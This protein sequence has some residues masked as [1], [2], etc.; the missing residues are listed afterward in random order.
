MT[1][2][3]YVRMVALRPTSVTWHTKSIQRWQHCDRPRWHY[4]RR[5]FKDGSIAT[6]L[7]DMTYEEYVRMV[8]LVLGHTLPGLEIMTERMAEKPGVVFEQPS[9]LPKDQI[10]ALVLLDPGMLKSKW[11]VK[12]Y[13][14]WPVNRMGAPHTS[15]TWYKVACLS[16][17][18]VIQNVL[19]L[20][21]DLNPGVHISCS[22]KHGVV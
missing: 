18:Q 21:R 4:I 10:K 9:F 15:W 5:V 22:V 1:Y 2:E 13:F 7:G 14:A 6:D 17:S 3:E 12:N 19:L 8:R 11:Q 16:N 20:V